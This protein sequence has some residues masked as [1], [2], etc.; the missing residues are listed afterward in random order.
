ML[1]DRTLRTLQSLDPPLLGPA[2]DAAIG[3]ASIDVHLGYT[4]SID[5]GVGVIDLLNI[6][7]DDWHTF[8]IPQD[9]LIL[10]SGQLILAETL[11]RFH[12]WPH[13]SAQTVGKS[14][15][16]RCG[17]FAVTG[18]GFA[19]AGFGWHVKDPATNQDGCVLTLEL[20]NCG[21]RPLLI[22]PGQKIGQVC[23]SALDQDAERPYGSAGLGSHYRESFG[24]RAPVTGEGT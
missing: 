13:L 11:E 7:P 16:A 3:A 9:G 8:A 21:R 12:V 20:F 2:D 18:A 5:M 4:Y 1:S 15:Y 17:L 14:T 23:F 10:A 6:N 24:V 22:H 19:E